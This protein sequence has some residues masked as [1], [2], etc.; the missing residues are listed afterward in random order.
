M[1]GALSLPDGGRDLVRIG[2]SPEEGG[3]A[4]P[5]R[6][7]PSDS[8]HMNTTAGINEPS[9]FY[10]SA[11]HKPTT[12]HVTQT[13]QSSDRRENHLLGVTSAVLPAM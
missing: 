3:A 1:A 9:Y 13:G 4:P 12:E 2:G 10:H 5:P 11:N 8:G 6:R 7:T